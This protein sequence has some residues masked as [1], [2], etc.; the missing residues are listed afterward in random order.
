MPLNFEQLDAHRDTIERLNHEIQSG[1]P[2]VAAIVARAEQAV[3]DLASGNGD[4]AEATRLVG[5]AH[6]VMKLQNEFVAELVEELQHLSK[7]QGFEYLQKGQAH[8]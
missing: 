2:R 1:L 3:N 6:E 7:Y 5:L 8:G 4:P